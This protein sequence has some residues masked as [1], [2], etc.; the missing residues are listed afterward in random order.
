MHSQCASRNVR[1]SPLAL[2]AP[3]SLAFTNPIRFLER[4][5]LVETFKFFT[6]SSNAS[7]KK[8]N[9]QEICF[10]KHVQR[11]RVLI[12]DIICLPLSLL[13]STRIISSNKC[14]G[15]LLITLYTVL[16]NV[17]QASLWK[18]IIIDVFGKLPTFVY[19][20]MHLQSVNYLLLI[21]YR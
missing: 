6:C 1:T 7:F 13:S 20:V 21:C 8:S 19:R 11:E 15:D 12:K 18:T 10:L 3:R 5:T 4:R 14:L 16:S 2:L 9:K 17:L